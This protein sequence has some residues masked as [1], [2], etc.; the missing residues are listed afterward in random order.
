MAEFPALPLFTDA[1][2]GDTMHLSAA[3]TGAYLMLLMAAWRS[4]DCKLPDDDKMLARMARMD[5]RLWA[6]NKDVVMAFWSQDETQKWYQRRLIDERKYVE[7]KREQNIRAGN[8]S[9]LKRNGR[10][11]TDVINPLQPE[12]NQPTPIT[13]THIEYYSNTVVPEAA[14][15]A[16]ALPK[17]NQKL[18]D[19]A[20]KIIASIDESVA[21]HYG[22]AQC[23][24]APDSKDFA[25]A[26]SLLKAGADPDMC[27]EIIDAIVQR[28]QA[29]GAATPRSLKYFEQAIIDALAKPNTPTPNLSPQEQKPF[30]LPPEII[31]KLQTS[32]IPDSGIHQWFDGHCDFD[33]KNGVI[34]APDKFFADKIEQKYGSSLR[35]VF[36]KD[37]KI[38][39]T[40]KPM[41]EAAE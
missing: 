26:T 34:H 25:T 12:T 16:A 1:F 19:Q 41:Q 40:Q 5:A 29:S 31:S 6:A 36:G 39:V 38:S 23:R 8:A 32:T 11:S 33:L 24:L 9:A 4:K 27:V 7:A 3:Q 17:E 10:H 18:K 35:A 13:H 14:K 28:R 20:R 2:I 21:K 37:M 15:D 22:A 30:V